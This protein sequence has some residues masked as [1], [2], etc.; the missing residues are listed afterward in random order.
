M[1]RTVGRGFNSRRLHI[2]LARFRASFFLSRENRR[3][4]RAA[5]SADRRGKGNPA[6]SFARK[7]CLESVMLERIRKIKTLLLGHTD[8]VNLDQ[9]FIN[10]ICLVGG[11]V[12]LISVPLNYF[13]VT[14]WFLTGTTLFEA[15]LLLGTYYYSRKT[16][17]Y[18]FLVWPVLMSMEAF[19]AVQWFY[20]GGSHGGAQYYFFIL[21]LVGSAAVERFQRALMVSIMIL[22]ALSLL[23]IEESWPGLVLAYP[24]PLARLIDVAYSFAFGILLIGVSVTVLA[25]QNRELLS[26]IERKNRELKADLE[27]ARQLQDEVF[28]PSRENAK[29][30]DFAMEYS[31]SADVGGDFYDITPIS[32]GIRFLLADMKGHGVNSALTAMLVK[33]EWD[34]LGQRKLSP[35]RAIQELN[36]QLVHRYRGSTIL[37]AC[38]ADVYPDSMVYASAGFPPGFITDGR[39]VRSLGTCGALIG[40]QEQFDCREKKAEIP[41]GGRIVLFS[42]GFIEEFDQQGDPMAPGWFHD[43]L[44]RPEKSSRSLLDALLNRFQRQTGKSIEE[45]SD[46]ITILVTGSRKLA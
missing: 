39:T 26:R 10:M 34:H 46:D 6:E 33:S 30:Y 5:I 12:A 14:G 28:H 40:L 20:N 1:F 13:V 29:G 3:A 32:G 25:N 11:A 18:R 2:E 22:V 35:S 27:F 45:A 7:P 16:G 17:N 21:A 15:V 4:A 43:L 44:A 19:M 42:D 24:S 36:T 38:V 41:P 31:A 8:Y 23:F 37:C 9:Q